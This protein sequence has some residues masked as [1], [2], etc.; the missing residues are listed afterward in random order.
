[1]LAIDTNLI[2]RYLTNDHPTQ[3]RRARTIVASQPV[4]ASVTVMLETAWVLRSS[5]GYSE[6]DV[7]VALR[8]FGGLPGVALEDAQL[9]WSALDQVEKGMG[10]ADALHLERSR[11]CDGFLTFDRDLVKAAQLGGY[12]GV[13]AP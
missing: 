5:Y 6:R 10:F 7:V 13:R 12:E 8:A 4:F 1:M 11:H 9:V 2:V 3:S